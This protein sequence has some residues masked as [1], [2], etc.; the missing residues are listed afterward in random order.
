MKTRLNIRALVF[1]AL[2]SW[3]ATPDAV[4]QE[5]PASSLKGLAVVHV[6]SRHVKD[7]AFQQAVVIG[8]GDARFIGLDDFGGVAFEFSFQGDRMSLDLPGKTVE[9]NSKKLKRLLS[10]KLTKAEFLAALT[11]VRPEG[12]LSRREY[13]AEVWTEPRHKKLTVT[14]SD[15]SM[16]P[17]EPYYPRR[18]VIAEKD[19]LFD[20]KWL[21]VE[22]Q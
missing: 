15:F 5:L 16:G 11:H 13:G 10:L 4:G 21:N 1:V 14:F 22:F 8:G 7:Q 9:A 3:I 12:W 2:T 6:R 18:I 19:H 20:L 17:A